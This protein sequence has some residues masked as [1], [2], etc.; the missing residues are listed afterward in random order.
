VPITSAD[1]AQ[2]RRFDGDLDGRSRSAD[3]GQGMT[4]SQWRAL[5]DL[6]QRAFIAASHA[7]SEAFQRELESDLVACMADAHAFDAFRQ[8]VAADLDRAARLERE[9]PE[10]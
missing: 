1:I 3:R 8:L 9:T 6:R 10:R 2:Y 5:D 7:G 4:E